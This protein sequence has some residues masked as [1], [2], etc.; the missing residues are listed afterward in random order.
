MVTPVP[1]VSAGTATTV[2]LAERFCP[3]GPVA[4]IA[5]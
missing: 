1:L 3:F 4:V 5:A 2:M